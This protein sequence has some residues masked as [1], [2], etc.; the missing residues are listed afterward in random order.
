MGIV[1]NFLNE[2]KRS[3]YPI[4][5]GGI[6]VGLTQYGYSVS[7]SDIVVVE[8]RAMIKSVPARLGS[9]AKRKIPIV[10]IVPPVL[11]LDNPGDL[12]QHITAQERGYFRGR[13]RIQ[14]RRIGDVVGVL[15]SIRRMKINEHMWIVLVHQPN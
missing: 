11:L 13:V 10:I 15:S 2:V 1:Q 4:F 7:E 3:P 12:R 14:R 9:P 8:P 5:K 6:C